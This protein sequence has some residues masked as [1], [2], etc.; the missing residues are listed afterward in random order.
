M[1]RSLH[2]IESLSTHARAPRCAGVSVAVGT[3]IVRA[4]SSPDGIV[5][6]SIDGRP[7]SEQRV[8]DLLALDWR[9]V[10][11]DAEIMSD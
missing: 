6:W 10:T 9:D 7:Q 3:R 2:T 1:S 8:A 11:S 4:V 5:L